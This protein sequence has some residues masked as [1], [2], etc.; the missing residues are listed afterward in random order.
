[1]LSGRLWSVNAGEREDLLF[2]SQL[3]PWPVGKVWILE[4]KALASTASLF[5]GNALRTIIEMI[6]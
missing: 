2:L 3:W 6:P 1:M 5:L 4:L